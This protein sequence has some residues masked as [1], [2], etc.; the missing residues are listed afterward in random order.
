M[1]H[2]DDVVRRALSA[3]DL[4][5]YET[6][7]RS[8][9]PIQLAF[10]TM[11]GEQRAFVLLVWAAGVGF[12]A[13]AVF[14]CVQFAGATGPREMAGWAGLAAFAVFSL[15]MLKLWFWMEVQKLSILRQLKRIELQLSASFTTRR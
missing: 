3:E 13:L 11:R 14:A 1:T 2:Y 9:N 10:D 12:L 7:G 5:L 15:G 4:S 6:L 8:Q